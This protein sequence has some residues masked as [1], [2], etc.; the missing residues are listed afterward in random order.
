M[1][2]PNAF[3]KVAGPLCIL[4]ALGWAFFIWPANF[5]WL[6]PAAGALFLWF[7]WSGE[8][9]VKYIFLFL[10]TVGG[11]GMTK[12]APGGDSLAAI[13]AAVAEVLC[14]W[15]LF[16]A[17][18]G[19]ESARR[20][21]GNKL[22]AREAETAVR[23]QDLKDALSRYRLHSAS[24]LASARDKGALAAAV[25]EMGGASGPDEIKSRLEDLLRKYFPGAQVALHS[26]APRDFA[27]RWVAERKIPLLVRN[28]AE[29]SRFPHGSFQA[30]ESSLMVLPLYLFGS[31][32]G[33]VRAVSP[34]RDRFKA[35][36]LRGAELSCTL[37]GVSM[38]NV[39]L[40]EKVRDMAI[41]DA[42]TGLYTHRAFQ[43]RIEEE[44]LRSARSKEPF[45]VI[46]TDI[47]HFKSYN[48]TY[49]HQAGDTV[50]KGVAAVMA[51]GVRDIDFVARYGGEE[52]IIVLTGVHKWEARTVAEQ[53]RRDLEQKVFNFGGKISRVTSSFGVAEFP[54][55][56]A[57][58]S[59]LVRAADERL[60]KA[61]ET[62][63]NK[64][65]YE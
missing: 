59:Q 39:C 28:S 43:S 36:D 24:A 41:K 62:G 10:I 9:E 5:L 20:E 42:L 51:G 50:L 52:F 37:A 33:F 48:D 44:I 2:R 35:A 18:A 7:H 8:K 32:V 61:K 49:G 19:A 16:F 21:A 34:E 65:V 56:G 46:M 31:I 58:A 1:I 45:S 4:G 3:T 30:G 63:R 57:A 54:A 15:L 27:D 55:E 14:L 40:F 22:A 25:K 11:F 13:G 6:Y 60:Y 38:E 23:V 12:L 64:V 47:D 53:L 29:D 17:L 26:G